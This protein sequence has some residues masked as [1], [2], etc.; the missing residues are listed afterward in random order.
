MPPFDS[1]SINPSSPPLA[2]VFMTL[3]VSRTQSARRPES[4]D[5]REYELLISLCTVFRCVSIV[6]SCIHENSRVVVENMLDNNQ[7]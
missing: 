4:L 1:V 7:W 5:Y 2:F 3:P 6:K